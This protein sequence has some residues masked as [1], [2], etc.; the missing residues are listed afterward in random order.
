LENTFNGLRTMVTRVVGQGEGTRS[1]AI[2]A[3]ALLCCLA[4]VRRHTA[5]QP[6][7]AGG[8]ASPVSRQLAS[9]RTKAR[10]AESWGLGQKPTKAAR[11]LWKKL[12][13][14]SSSPMPAKSLASLTRCGGG[15]GG[16]VGAPAAP[17][18]GARGR[19]SLK[20]CPV[21][22]AVRGRTHAALRCS[23]RRW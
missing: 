2:G 10:A 5:A 4:P 18:Q 16:G 22:C 11:T 3:Q 8:R 15:G 1:G 23:S 9:D 7:G 20:P 13:F 21:L 14:S 17:P 19:W 12:V 6:D